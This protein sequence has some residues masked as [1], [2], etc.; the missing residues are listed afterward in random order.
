MHVDKFI[1]HRGA[2]SDFIENTIEAFQIAKAAGFN[3]F[4]TDV[5]MSSDGELFLFHDKTPKRFADCDKNVI[6]MTLAELKQIQLADSV[7]KVKAKIPT[8]REYLDWASEN[9]VFTNLELKI[10]TQDKNTSKS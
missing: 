8:L 6:E 7:L 2:N 1:S 9:D 4:E 5:Q 3:W 10:S